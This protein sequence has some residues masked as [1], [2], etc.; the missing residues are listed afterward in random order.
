MSKK[1]DEKKQLAD[2]MRFACQERR[3]KEKKRRTKSVG[4]V[5]GIHEFTEEATIAETMLG[6]EIG[7]L[8]GTLGGAHFAVHGIDSING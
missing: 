5:I 4:K 7:C 3:R 1:S 6:G 8:G 2:D